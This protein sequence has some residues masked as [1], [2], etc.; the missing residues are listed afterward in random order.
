MTDQTQQS[1][2]FA[3]LKNPVFLWLWIGIVA[4]SIGSFAQTVGAQWLFIHEPNA[5]TI[6]S[7]VST[8][9]AL[10]VML[11]ALPAGVISD[12]FDRRILMILI[13]VYAIGIALLL[14]V[15]GWSGT[16]SAPLLLALTFL[17]GAAGALQLP[18]WQP[19]MT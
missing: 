2:V 16:L 19:L 9:N 15:L 11:L 5:A 1:S 13:Q 4:S 18:T 3:P 6:V 8:A 12:A 17:V 7:L 10:P 14:A